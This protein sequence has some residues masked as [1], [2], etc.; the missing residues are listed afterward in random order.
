MYDNIS[1][2]KL[3][4]ESHI[5]YYQKKQAY[6]KEIEYGIF[7]PWM[8]PPPNG[9]LDGIGGVLDKDGTYVEESACIAFGN[10]RDRFVGTYRY[11]INDLVINDEK[12]IYLGCFHKQWGHFIVDF[13]PRLWYFLSCNN[14]YR[15]VYTSNGSRIDGNYLEFLRLLGITEERITYVEHPTQYGCIVIPSVSYISGGGYTSQFKA[16]FNHITAC[17]KLPLEPYKK[18]Y[19]SRQH[20]NLKLSKDIGEKSIE[21]NFVKNGFQPI[22]MEELSLKEQIFYISHCEEVA[23]L[24]GTL[25]HNIMFA[26][27]N[28]KLIILNK[29]SRLNGHQI[30]INQ[31]VGN[32]VYY[33]DVYKEPYKRYP[34]SYGSGPFLVSEMGIKNY[35]MDKKYYFIKQH[36]F[37]KLRNFFVYSLRCILIDFRHLFRN[38][39][40]VRILYKMVFR[41]KCNEIKSCT[42][43]AN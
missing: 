20:L 24:S 28:V 19:L 27:E 36:V 18:I 12:V 34:L 37:S 9:P 26:N 8:P 13:T 30:I 17:V 11:D 39:N 6:I 21:D 41:N 25:C 10:T 14:E 29:T 5:D 2:D 1:T 3:R 4:G 43:G 22:Y 42:K 40:R 16:V 33:I 32:E 35:F 23:A 31:A 15:I 7:L 38:N